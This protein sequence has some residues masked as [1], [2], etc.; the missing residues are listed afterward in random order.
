MLISFMHGNENKSLKWESIM[1]KGIWF[2][3]SSLVMNAF[4]ELDCRVGFRIDSI[5]G[6][7]SYSVS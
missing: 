4:Y 6:I 7:H 2:Y 3:A 5:T 1:S